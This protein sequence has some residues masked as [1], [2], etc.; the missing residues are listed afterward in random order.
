M[1]IKLATLDLSDTLTVK[2]NSCSTPP[3]E[4]PERAAVIGVIVGF[5]Q[6]RAPI[7]AHPDTHE[8]L[9]GY[10]TVPLSDEDIGRKVLIVLARVEKCVPV[11]VGIIQQPAN[12]R[13]A[14]D[15]LKA[16][17]TASALRLDFTAEKEITFTCGASSLTL[18][19]AGK[20]ILRGAFILSQASGVHRI[21]GGSVQIN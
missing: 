11:I 3:W 6:A 21:Q 13:N 5:T 1:S 2:N 4:D 9:V 19:R 14:A 16:E 20:I 12:V 8:Q 15:G 7:V 10:S 17:G 18:T